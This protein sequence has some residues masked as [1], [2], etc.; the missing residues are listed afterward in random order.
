[1]QKIIV[2]KIERLIQ[3]MKEDYFPN[4][5][6]HRIVL[7]LLG[8]IGQNPDLTPAEELAYLV[9]ETGIRYRF[10][11]ESH[12]TMSSSDINGGSLWVNTYKKKPLLLG[13][14][15]ERNKQSTSDETFTTLVQSNCH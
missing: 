1:M 9:V 6:S 4:W 12:V 10:P 11:L 3:I 13:D 2:T 5:N 14:L 8:P 7:E 15:Y